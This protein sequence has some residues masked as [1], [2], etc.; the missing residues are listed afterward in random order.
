ML[1]YHYNAQ[2]TGVWRIGP[3][4]SSDIIVVRFQSHKTGKYDGYVHIKTSRDDMVLPVTLRVLRGGLVSTPRR[5]EFAPTV[6]TGD[7]LLRR[8]NSSVYAAP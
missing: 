1:T 7:I 8:P 3:G 4:A 5:V 2:P 6:I